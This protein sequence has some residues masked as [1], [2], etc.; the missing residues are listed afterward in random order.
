MLIDFSDLPDWFVAGMI[1]ALVLGGA[2]PVSGPLA[3]VGYVRARRHPYWNAVWYWAWSTVLSAAIM[4]ACIGLR[5]F[6]VAAILDCALLWTLA[7]FLIP[8]ERRA[9]L[10][11]GRTARPQPY[12]VPYPV[13]HPM[14]QVPQQ[15]LHAQ[16]YAGWPR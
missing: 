8:S 2:I 10:Q 1:A 9:R 15:Q 6:F 13:P 11:Y 4:V 3:A 14:P 5:I 7:W 12:A 16:Q